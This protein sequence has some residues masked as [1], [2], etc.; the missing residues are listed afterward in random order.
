M[1]LVSNLKNLVIPQEAYHGAEKSVFFK[2]Q[3]FGQEHQK[4]VLISFRDI[5]KI[6]IFPKFH[7]CGS[8]IVPATPF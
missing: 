8:K 5:H 3:T 7:R 4:I 6:H 2:L 1:E